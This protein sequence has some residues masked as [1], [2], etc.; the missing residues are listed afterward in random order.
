MGRCSSGL[1]LSDGSDWFFGIAH[2]SEPTQIE[3]GEDPP[4]DAR[5]KQSAGHWLGRETWDEERRL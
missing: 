1:G 4:A 3:G 5:R 2:F